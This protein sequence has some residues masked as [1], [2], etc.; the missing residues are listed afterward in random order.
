MLE[1][2]HIRH[3]HPLL[4]QEVC[5]GEDFFPCVAGYSRPRIAKLIVGSYSRDCCS[6]VLIQPERLVILIISMA[7]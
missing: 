6:F 1:S 4:V 7:C 5:L 2:L 3:V